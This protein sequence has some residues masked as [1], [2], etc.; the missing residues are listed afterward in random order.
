M[1]TSNKPTAAAKKE[2]EKAD[3]AT[4]EQP[5]KVTVEGFELIRVRD[6]APPFN[7]ALR[8]VRRMLLTDSMTEQ[9][10]RPAV[11]SRGLPLP[12]KPY[13]ELATKTTDETSP[14]G[15]ADQAANTDTAS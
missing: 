15:A 6:D 12:V 7:G 10:D 13:T 11:D 3:E 2:A 8:T 9:K 4:V 5:T 14:D 1:A